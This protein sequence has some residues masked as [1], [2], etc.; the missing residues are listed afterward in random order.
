MPKT[1]LP[2][3]TL[4]YVAIN[5]KLSSVIS[6][7][8][9]IR[10][11]A[12]KVIKTLNNKGIKTIMLTGDNKEVAKEVSKYLNIT[13]YYSE[14]TP[15][16]KAEIIQKLKTKYG[17]VM[18]CGDGINDSVALTKADIG[19]SLKGATDIAMD[20]ADVVLINDD[21]T[22]ILNLFKVSKKTFRKIKQNLFWAFFY[23]FLMIP[24]AMGLI[25]GL[26][27]TPALASIAMMFSS[28]F[29]VL[30]SLSLNKIKFN[31]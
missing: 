29:V 17:T 9:I 4:V 24:I 19:L 25:K 13:E 14:T 28:I 31:N 6:I 21:L 26:T 7:T 1:K 27:I 10:K 12:P 5:N 18:M 20:C 8:D 22:G 30:N 11:E 3:T 15:K 2:N 23:N 16:E